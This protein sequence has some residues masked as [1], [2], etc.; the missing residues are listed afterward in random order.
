VPIVGK[1]RLAGGAFASWV[2]CDASVTMVTEFDRNYTESVYYQCPN[3]KSRW[4]PM[5]PAAS[6]ELT[7]GLPSRTTGREARRWIERQLRWERILGRLRTRPARS[8]RRA[9]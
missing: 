6:A 1:S 3:T 2:D 7:A 5:N 9:A 4:I 8:T